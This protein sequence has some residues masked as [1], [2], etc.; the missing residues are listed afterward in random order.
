MAVSGDRLCVWDWEKFTLDVPVGWDAVHYSVQG[1]V[2]LNGTDPVTAFRRTR[3]TAVELRPLGR[4]GRHRRPRARHA[5]RR[6]TSARATS[7]TARP[8]PATRS[9]G[10]S[11]A[12]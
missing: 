8:A 5:L 12:G 4:P 3:D 9:W 6:S 1:D 10:T 11:R 2:V 7:P